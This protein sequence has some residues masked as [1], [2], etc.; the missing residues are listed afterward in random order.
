[1]KRFCTGFLQQLQDW[2][3][4]Y[5]QIWKLGIVIILAIALGAC[6]PAQS[7]LPSRLVI[8]TPSGPST[9]NYPLNQSAYS[10]FGYIYDSLIQEHPVTGA[11]EPGLAES[12]QVAPSGREII[13]TL[14]EDLKWSDGKPMTADDILFTY[15]DVYLNDQIPS[16]FKDILRV[17]QSRQF[18][19]IE[20]LDARRVK[21][22]VTEPFAPF[23][24]YVGGLPIL[25][26]H[27][28]AETVRKTDKDG[29]PEFLTTWGTDTDPTQIVGNGA[30]RLRNYTSN[31]RVVLEKNPYYWRQDE[32][33]NSQPFIEQVVWRIIESTDNQLLNF[34]SGSLDALEVQPEAFPLLKPEEDRGK[35]TIHSSGP[36]TGT[37]FVAFN[38]NQ[39]KNAQGKP[40]VDPVKSRWFNNRSFRQAVYYGI[41]RE[42]MNNNIYLGLGAPQHSSIP[43]QSPFYLSPEEGLRTYEYN[44]EKA[45]QLLLSAGFSYDQA[46]K[47]IDDQGNPVRF[48]LL[49]SAGKKVREQMATQINQDLS[50]LGIQ[51]DTQFLSFNT[52]V[53]RLS[54]ARDWDA[55]LGGFT[56]GS[57]V[58]PHGGYNIWSIN[59]RLHTFNQGP[60]PG[61]EGIT[62]WVVSDWEQR[63]DDI[64]VQASQE[65]DENKRRQLYGEFQKIVAE[66][67]PFLYMVNPLSFEAVR[68]RFENFEYTPLGGAFWNLYELKIKE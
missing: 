57:G 47:L 13:I 10:V 7:S 67:L 46:G 33:G 36:D 35:Y 49:V 4:H 37:I 68:D 29:N 62:G 28:L 59:G 53:E 41:N 21:F 2:Q 22:S 64:F 40:F 15:K 65:F 50:R 55:Y 5:Q 48:T 9:F 18:P 26:A 66:E 38:L 3:L 39:G 23:V 16:S 17:G 31:Q 54:Q 32:A 12:W 56:G 30:Y 11:L 60:Q 27:I 42:V 43:V 52:Y 20:K 25:P 63:V 61:E 51:M 34:R 24:R 45:K 44:P 14:R 1:M 8:P 19:T 58:E 6:R